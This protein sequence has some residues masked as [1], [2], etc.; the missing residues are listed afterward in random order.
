MGFDV[1]NAIKTHP[2][3]KISLLGGDVWRGLRSD[4]KDFFGFNEL[5]FSHI[6][7]NF[8]KAWK[9]HREATLNLIVVTGEIQFQLSADGEL[10]QSIILGDSH[11]QRLVLPPMIWFGF[12]CISITPGIIASVS[13][14]LHDDSEIERA[15]VDQFSVQWDGF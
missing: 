10:F 7:P 15:A 9:M 14:M 11:P 3:K 1:K 12:K 2:R 6:D 8:V 4:D 13:S 5:Y